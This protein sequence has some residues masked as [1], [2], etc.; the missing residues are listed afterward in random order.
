MA[1]GADPL[2]LAK[3]ENPTVW[4]SGATVK[5]A[6]GMW[7]NHGGGYS[8]RICKNTPGQVTEECFQKNPLPFAKNTQILQHINGTQVRNVTKLREAG[9]SGRLERAARRVA[10]RGH[11]SSGR[12]REREREARASD[13]L[14]AGACCCCCLSDPFSTH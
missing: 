3:S 10:R 7:A 5:V 11:S 8:Y 14:L 1:Q 4:K 6:W 9:A 12:E 13:A 2:Q